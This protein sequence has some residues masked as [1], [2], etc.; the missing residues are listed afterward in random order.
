MIRKV[1]E[2]TEMLVSFGD[3]AVT[4]N[5]PGDAQPARRRAGVL[6]PG[7]R[8]ERRR[9]TPRRPDDRDRAGAAATACGRSTRSC[10]STSTCPAARRPPTCIYAVLERRCSRDATAATRA[11]TRFGREDRSR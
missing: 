4:G 5:V 2:R 7:L 1:R 10:R 8:R 6:R 9:S 3:C 11:A